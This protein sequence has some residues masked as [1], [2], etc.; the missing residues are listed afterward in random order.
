MGLVPTM[1][2]LHAGHRSLLARAR[3][4]CP[5]VI[6]TIF[7]NPI[8]FDNREDLDKYPRT[9]E[10]DVR[11][12]QDVGVDAIF[13][14]SIETMYPPQSSTFVEVKGLQDLLCGRHRPGHFVGVATVV[15][16][17]F[18]IVPADVA[19]FGLK[20][21]QQ[22]AVI[23]RMVSDLNF[24]IEIR[25]CPTVREPDGL[26]MSSRNSRLSADHRRQATVLYR[27]LRRVS[28]KVSEGLRDVSQ[29]RRYALEELSSAPDAVLDYLEWVD[30]STLL[31]V[32][33][34]H[35]PTVVAT[36]VQ[37]GGVR[38]IDNM[39]LEPGSPS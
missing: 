35:Q 15:A 22:T 23:Q 24:P 20:D 38:L 26:A 3:N 2:N 32:D 4:E 31:A 33:K 30:P 9:W 21:F 36:A 37:F 13:A 19:Y 16:K 10:A 6:A 34:V 27:M 39:L 28:D 18:N 5:F 7:V 12:C 1:G 25:L 14:P 11:L 29:L 8:Q 17:L